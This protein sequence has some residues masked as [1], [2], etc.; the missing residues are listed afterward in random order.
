[1]NTKLISLFLVPVLLLTTSPAIADDP[2]PDPQEPNAIVEG[3][4]AVVIGGIVAVGLWKLCKLIPDPTDIPHP[5]APPPTNPPPVINPTNNVPP[6]NAPPKPPWWKRPFANLRAGS[7]TV[8]HYSIGQYGYQD[9]EGHPYE[10]LVQYSLQS[11]TNAL[12]WKTEL[13]CTGWLSSGAALFAYYSNGVPLQTTYST[14]F[15]QTNYVPWNLGTGSEPNKMFRL[16]S[17]H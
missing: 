11:S 14:D 5:Q 10:T 17:V 16:L 8:A 3:C 13:T 15:G 4:L 7:N 6:T 1:M 9:M 2:P 12:D